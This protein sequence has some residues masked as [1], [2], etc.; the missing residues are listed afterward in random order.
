MIDTIVLTLTQDMFTVVEPDR[1]SPSARG[2]LDRSYRLGGRANMRCFQNPTKR[3]LKAKIFKPRLTLTGRI[4]KRHNFEITLRV[5]ISL[6]KL[7][8]GDSFNELEN[9]DIYDA[10]IILS[11]KLKGMGI[12]VN[13]P[14]IATAPIS[15]IH[16]SKNIPLTDGS[17]PYTYLKEIQK[18]NLSL[19]LDFD[20]TNFRGEGH[21]VKFRTNYH[22]IAFYDKLKE[23]FK[24]R[25]SEKKVEEKDNA[26]QFDL[27]EKTPV[28]KPFELLRMEV[29]LNQRQKIR[30]VLGKIGLKIEPTFWSLFQT[31]VSREVL[32]YHL[33]LIEDSYP[34]L[35]YSKPKS[36]KDFIAQF[37]IDNSKAKLKDPI[38]A[39]GF[40]IA[41][42]DMGAREIRELLKKYPTSTWYRFIRRMNEFSYPKNIPSPFEPI[43]NAIE[44]FRVLKLVDFQDKMLNNVK[45][46]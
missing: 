12:K 32:L 11:Q 30:H 6:Q 3:E 20:Q 31:K 28:R 9:D 4:N 1:F 13:E 8:F 7:L 14:N 15:A 38:L 23:L 37:I 21:S 17:I 26:I 25:I 24:A 46:H 35:L 2:L 33:D 45:Y 36:N 29:R 5:E 40:H 16:Y 27:F 44:E 10:V 19:R 22:E 41:L 34:K 43:R 39:L 42:E 18:A